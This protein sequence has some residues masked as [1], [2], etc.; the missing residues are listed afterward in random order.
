M[1]YSRPKW[2]NLLCAV[3]GGGVNDVCTTQM[4]NGIESKSNKRENGKE[5]RKRLFTFRVRAKCLCVW[6]EQL[7]HLDSRVFGTFVLEKKE[8]VSISGG[9][10]VNNIVWP[11]NRIKR[12]SINYVF[13]CSVFIYLWW[14]C[15][16]CE[17]ARTPMLM[18]SVGAHRNVYSCFSCVCHECSKIIESYAVGVYFHAKMENTF[19]KGQTHTTIVG[20]RSKP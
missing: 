15:D 19:W 1:I 17:R 3:D 2:F 12:D 5:K 10:G 13:S 7:F 18:R 20:N 8:E 14:L 9:G 6:V 4:C 16:L 11:T